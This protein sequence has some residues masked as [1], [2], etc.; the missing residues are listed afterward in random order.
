MVL[1]WPMTNVSHVGT[2]RDFACDA[3]ARFDRAPRLEG[4]IASLPDDAVAGLRLKVHAIELLEDVLQFMRDELRGVQ[5]RFEIDVRGHQRAVL[6]PQ[7]GAGSGQTT[8]DAEDRR[9]ARSHADRFR[10]QAC[11]TGP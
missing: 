4:T 11:A 3:P 7:N 1:V 10:P 9:R 6:M 5:R 2:R 8:R